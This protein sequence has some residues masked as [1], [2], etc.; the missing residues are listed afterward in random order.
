MTGATTPDP[1]EIVRLEA[2]IEGMV[3]GVGF[4][5]FVGTMAKELGLVGSAANEY[6]GTVTAVLEG[7]RAACEK[8]LVRL[9]SGR[10]PGRVTGFDAVY[11]QAKGARGF[12]I[13]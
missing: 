5:W 13:R 1:E 2:R 10:T 3:Q 4:R 11:M 6:D 7:R 12:T 9:T 8:F